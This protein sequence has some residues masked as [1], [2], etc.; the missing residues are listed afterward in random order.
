MRE[1]SPCLL[2][3]H[4]RVLGEPDAQALEGGHDHGVQV[5]GVQ[6]GRAAALVHDVAADGAHRALPVR[7]LHGRLHLREIE[8]REMNICALAV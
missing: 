6:R 1:K 5:S 3:E 8:E 2:V 4:V 7:R